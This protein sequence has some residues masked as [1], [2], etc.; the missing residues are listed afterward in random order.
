MKRTLLSSL[1]LG[2]ALLVAALLSP[3][4]V[5]AAGPIT[6]TACTDTGTTVSCEL[7]AKAQGGTATLP[8]T[9]VTKWWGFSDAAA[10]TPT[11][12]GPVLV[13]DQGDTVNVTLHN[14]LAVPTSILFDGQAMVPDLAGVAAGS[15]T[16][17]SFT[18]GAPG[19][20]LYEA[21]MIPGSQYQVSMGL[22][23]VLVVR[24]SLAYTGVS[25]ARTDGAAAVT[26]SLDTVTDAAVL[27]TDTGSAV[28]GTGIP[29]GTTISAVTAGVSFTMSAPATADGTGVTITRTDASAT[30]TNGSTMVTDAA[31]LAT[32]LGSAVSGTG[33]PAGAT[34]TAAADGGPL[35]LSA[36]AQAVAYGVGTGYDDEALVVL[37]E[38]DPALNN[39]TTPSSFDLRLFAPKFSLINGKA[40]PATDSITTAGGKSLLLRYVNAGIQHHSIGVLGLRQSVLA[41]DGSELA[42]PR[43]MVAE[44]IAP[45]QSA[46]VLVS[47]PAST[48]DSTKYPLYDAALGL[49]NNGG[50]AFGGMLTLIDAAPSG[51]T[52]GDTV[53]PVTSNVAVDTA[54]GAL[55]ASV[56]DAATGSSGVTAAEYFIDATGASGTGTAMA[57]P[58]PT[59]PAAVTATIPSAT[60]AGLA[61]GSHTIYVHGQDGATPTANWGAFSAVTFTLDKAGPTVSA[62]ALT[63]NPPTG[64]TLTGTADD[65]A[66]GNSN[67]TAAEWFIG[68]PGADG[69]GNPMNLNKTAPIVSLTGTIP[70]GQSGVISVHARDA[71]GNWGA[72]ATITLSIDAAGPATTGVAANPSANNGSYGQSSSNAS[73]R[74]S[75][76]FDDSASGNSAIAAGEGF[77][78][79]V[80]ADGAGFPFAAT[81]G[82]FNAPSETGYADIPLTTINLLGTGNHTIYVHGKDA[83]GNWGAT[84]S[85][86]YLIDKTAPTFTGISLAPDPTLGATTVTLTVNGATDPLVG[87]LASGV[88]GGEYWIGTTVPAPG[89][90]TRFSG[91]TASIPVGS[92][93]PGTYTMGARIRDAAGNWS[94]TT[95]SATV[96]VIPDAI[97]SNGFETGGAPWGWTSRSTTSTTRLNVTTSPALVG[98]RSLQAQGN[99]TNYVQYSFGTAANPATPTYDAQF[100]FRPNGSSSTGKDI[101]RA[102]AGTSNTAFASPLFSVRYRLSGTTPQVQAQVGT[103]ANATWTNLLGGTSNNVIEVTWTS[104]GSLA[105]YVNGTLAQTLT[106]GTGSVSAVRLGS[107]TGT[108]NATLLYFDA[109]VSKR[110]VS[111]LVGP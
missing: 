108:G 85:I 111:P 20:Y 62:L 17:Y 58:F 66:T 28:S 92:L 64:T 16:V 88:A 96:A 73:V 93:A 30:V 32:D 4:A 40:Y 110:S 49:N 42:F 78:D 31:A 35:T 12:P 109:F 8:G 53:G 74:V 68:T 76:T 47:V 48:A 70:T 23:G 67:V 29:A 38:V 6:S 7:W 105:L 82:V 95:A 18:A 59:D 107:V 41:A 46:D 91:L 43:E 27:A 24:P 34:I 22:Y 65:S 1:V 99:N 55:S 100:T 79:T 26:T 5:A 9:T 52:A 102:A 14:D 39:S 89:G 13:A 94:T 25:V 101:L 2:P 45:G 51:T 37:G 61:S 80:G 50:Q 84:S 60:L 86:T 81:D 77:I 104:A 44:T 21:G 69:S 54:T 10:G 36:P 63:P 106:A 56:T 90:G 57:G 11:V 15:S 72:F 87:G 75:A 103:T 71:A 97:F 3:G 98:T 33:I 19:T 83:A